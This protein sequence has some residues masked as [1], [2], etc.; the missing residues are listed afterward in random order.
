MAGFHTKTFL[1]YD[2][3]MTPEIAW[4]NIKNFIPADKIIWEPFY[5][6]GKSGEYLEKLGFNVIHDKSDF[7]AIENCYPKKPILASNRYPILTCFHAVNIE[8]LT[9]N[10]ELEWQQKSFRIGE[11]PRK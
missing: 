9:N 6:D 1:K 10:R 8:A 3:Y 2:D 7:F 5:G 11:K 4:I